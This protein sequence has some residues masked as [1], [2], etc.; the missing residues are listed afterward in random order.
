MKCPRCGNEVGP[1][2]VFCGQCGAPTMSSSQATEV[3]N[4]P[5]SHSGYNMNIPPV[6]PYNSGMQPPPAGSNGPNPAASTPNMYNGAM[7]SSPYGPPNSSAVRPNGPQQQGGFYQDA[8]EAM[9]M[10]PGSNG[11]S[12]PPGYPPQGYGNM[13]MPGGYAGTGQFGS[14]VPPGVMPPYQAGNYAGPGYAPSQPFSSGQGYGTQPG[15]TPPPS[16][17]RN[18][19]I[20]VIACIFLVLALIA[21]VAF[22]ALYLVR[23]YAVPE[24][25]STPTAVPTSAPTATPIPSPTVGITPT[26]IPSPTAVPTP[27]PDPNFSWCGTT[28]TTNGFVVEY[29]NGW[30]EGQPDGTTISFT[31]PLAQTESAT[32]KTP[33]GT[34]TMNAI[35][36]VNSDLQNNF[37][38]KP[39]YTLVTPNSN[40]TIGGETWVYETATYKLDG[41]QGKDTKERVEVYATVHEQKAYIIELQAPD[42]SFDTVNLQVFELMLSKFQFQQPTT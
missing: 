39:G 17:Q 3:A 11:S 15:L 21:V 37:S 42:D 4:A 20:L 36:L 24:A 9:P 18:N 14:P 29:P 34:T 26:P 19:A 12:Y 8:T 7:P 1:E 10:M 32:F 40:A 35:D 16:K 27:A 31:N 23:S 13:S 5:T 30:E 28:C 22:G 41:A 2:E 6:P 25:S 33:P 38:M